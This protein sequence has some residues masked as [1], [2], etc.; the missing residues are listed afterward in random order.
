MKANPGDSY[1]PWYLVR[2][3]AREFSSQEL[4]EMHDS[5]AGKGEHHNARLYLEALSIHACQVGWGDLIEQSMLGWPTAAQRLA[6]S[7]DLKILEE[8]AL[9]ARA[10]RDR[11]RQSIF[12]EAI[13]IRKE[14]DVG[15][16]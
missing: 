2:L 9:R 11:D 7:V 14:E 13:R 3:A 6:R 16:R 1:T 8:E 10:R 15:A 4:C 12:E 5:A